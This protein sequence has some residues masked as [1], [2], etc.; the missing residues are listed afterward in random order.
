[1]I[2]ILRCFAPGSASLH[3]PKYFAIPPVI[4]GCTV[5]SSV[6][7]PANNVISP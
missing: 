1:M 2:S 3:T 6:K 4:L 7:N 5:K